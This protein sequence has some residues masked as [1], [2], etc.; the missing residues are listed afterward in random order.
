M[1]S[2]P[3]NSLA[4]PSGETY[5]L[6][7]ASGLVGSDFTGPEDGMGIA[8]PIRA[9][10]ELLHWKANKEYLSMWLV[11]AGENVIMVRAAIFL[12]GS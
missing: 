2:K 5:F 4:G 3:E 7:A 6:E 10:G 12:R 11:V 1:T 9:N 8:F